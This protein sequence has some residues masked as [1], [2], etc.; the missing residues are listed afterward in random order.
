[1]HVLFI[2]L[3]MSTVK[4][5]FKALESKKKFLRLY[6]SKKKKIHNT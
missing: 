5:N 6:R 4:N 3:F 1:M 2:V